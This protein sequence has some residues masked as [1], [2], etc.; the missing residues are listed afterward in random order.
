MLGVR[1]AK[2]PHSSGSLSRLC[3][4]GGLAGW[5]GDFHE[6]QICIREGLRVKLSLW[7]FDRSPWP[8]QLLLGNIYRPKAA[9]VQP[10]SKQADRPTQ[11]MAN[12]MRH[13]D[14]NQMIRSLASDVAAQLENEPRRSQLCATG[15]LE[16]CQFGCHSFHFHAYPRGEG[17][18]YPGMNFNINIS[19]GPENTVMPG[20][21]RDGGGASGED[22]H[23][24]DQ[25]PAKKKPKKSDKSDKVE[26]KNAGVSEGS[27]GKVVRDPTTSATSN[28]EGAVVA[29][30]VV[31]EDC[32]R[33]ERERGP[34]PA[35]FHP[36]VS[37]SS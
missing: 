7:T 23:D 24:H 5:L 11:S 18:R 14:R 13:S 34:P 16:G 27:E 20:T 37:S 36:S 22:R 26:K 12:P 17:G 25:G 33:L 15:L 2:W 32:V 4:I 19:W 9:C 30:E 3:C 1:L 29:P 28:A 35:G 10:V 8:N 6:L 31:E 21:T